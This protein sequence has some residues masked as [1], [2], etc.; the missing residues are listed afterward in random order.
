MYK[1]FSEGFPASKD[2]LLFDTEPSIMGD[3][4]DDYGFHA[5]IIKVKTTIKAI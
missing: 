5:R 4:P 3:T 2:N 1:K